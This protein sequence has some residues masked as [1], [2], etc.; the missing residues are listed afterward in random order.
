[1][2]KIITMLI[3]ALLIVS[4][5]GCTNTQDTA[6]KDICPGKQLGDEGAPMTK[7]EGFDQTV[8][9]SFNTVDTNG[10]PVTNNVFSGTERGTWLVFWQTDNHKSIT[11]L[12]R[13]NNML[14]IAEENGYKVV[15]IVMDGERNSK[16]A[17]EMT[18]ELNFTNI[19]WNDEVA[20]R[21]DGISDFFSK[22]F[23]EKNKEMY[24]QFTVM[25]ELGEPV[26]TRVNS[27]GQLQ[28]SCSLVTI[29][30]KKIE[31]MWKNND[32]NATYEELL[33][34]ERDGLGK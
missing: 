19:V 14:P 31:G 11:E 8:D 9:M 26:S 33:E 12:K 2:K 15:G 22:E 34:Q 10:N 28:T 32:S 13:L 4:L 21:Y 7:A 17:K 16:K 25:P 3:A 1:M 18:S 27:R 30:D 5:A 29:S 20:A 6:D 24:A 23:Y